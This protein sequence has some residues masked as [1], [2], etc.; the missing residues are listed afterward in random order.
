MKT[1]QI[2]QLTKTK[3][4]KRIFRSRSTSFLIVLSAFIPLVHD[5][6]P[7]NVEGFFGFSSARVMTYWLL[8]LAYGILPWLMVI[9]RTKKIALKRIYML[10]SLGPFYQMLIYIFDIRKTIFNDHEYK[11]LVYLVLMILVLFTFKNKNESKIKYIPLM[12]IGIFPFLHD[13]VPRGIEGIFGFNSLRVFFFTINL[14]FIPLLGWLV[15]YRSS[16]TELFRFAI[17]VPIFGLLID[18]LFHVLNPNVS[19]YSE[20]T[21]KS[22]AIVLLGII[23]SNEYFKIK[24]SKLL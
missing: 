4:K 1:P 11:I 12:L 16:V 6:I 18:L 8:M 17:I 2:E 9:F 5:L 19:A 15:Y 21:V 13:F 20:L 7:K 3:Q 24:L 10:I 22:I 23:V 14:I